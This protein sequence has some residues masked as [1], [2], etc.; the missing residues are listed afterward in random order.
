MSSVHM[1]PFDAVC[2]H[3]DLRA[4]Q[5][6]GIHW[7]TFILTDEPVTEPV[8]MLEEEAVLAGLRPSEFVAVRFGD[9][10]GISGEDEKT[11]S[12]SFG[13]EVPYYTSKDM[14]ESTIIQKPGFFR[15]IFQKRRQ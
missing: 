10:I 5:S 13:H 12:S 8:V 15:K 14:E 7:G 6:I 9:T 3:I 1:N 4:K 2:C 11:L